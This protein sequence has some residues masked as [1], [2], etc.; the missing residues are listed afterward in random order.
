MIGDYP[1]GRETG[2]PLVIYDLCGLQ[3]VLELMAQ[4]DENG[5]MGRVFFKCP[6]NMQGVS[7]IFCFDL[8]EIT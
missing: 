8:L 4:T 2:L 5:N 1:L 7:H 3:R 6:R